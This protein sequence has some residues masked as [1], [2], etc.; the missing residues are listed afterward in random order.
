MNLETAIEQFVIASK[1][2]Q[3]ALNDEFVRFQYL[4]TGEKE[5]RLNVRTKFLGIMALSNVRGFAKAHLQLVWSFWQPP[6]LVAKRNAH[7]FYAPPT[8]IEDSDLN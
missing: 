6:V 3:Q 8:V 1:N 2:L 4:G 7:K 5:S